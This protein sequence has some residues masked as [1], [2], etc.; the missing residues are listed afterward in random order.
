M[1]GIGIDQDNGELTA[2]VFDND[3]LLGGEPFLDFLCRLPSHKTT[4][5]HIDTMT[6]EMEAF[7][8]VLFGRRENVVL[9]VEFNSFVIGFC[10]ILMLISKHS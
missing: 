5:L 9:R 2:P 3:A 1:V 4:R 7:S 8:F 10:G 6:G